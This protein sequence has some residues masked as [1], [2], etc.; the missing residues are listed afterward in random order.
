MND[1]S[2]EK[3]EKQIRGQVLQEIDE[4]NEQ[5]QHLKENVGELCGRLTDIMTTSEEN[6]VAENQKEAKQLV[7]IAEY[8]RSNNYRIKEINER[9]KEML[10]SIEL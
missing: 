10:D 8:V 3:N 9:I 5:I 7:P 1:G 6:P 2:I 4:Q